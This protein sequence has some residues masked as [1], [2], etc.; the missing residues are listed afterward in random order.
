MKM[1]YAMDEKSF[2]KIVEFVHLKTG[3]R[4][5]E[6][7]KTM[8]I[9]RLRKHLHS[10]KLESFD[11]Y[12]DTIQ[13]S[14][15]ET[16]IFI[17]LVTTNE[18][19][20]FR[21]ERVWKYFREDFLPDWFNRNPSTRLKIWSAASSTGEE[22]YSLGILCEEFKKKNPTFNYEIIGTD[23]STKVLQLAEK[24]EYSGRSIEKFKTN[25]PVM[26]DKFMVRINEDTFQ[27][28]SVVRGHV[29]FGPHNLFL[30]YKKQAYFDI[31]F[32]RNVLIYFQTKDQE[33]V[34]EKI[35]KSMASDSI[36]VVG[37]SE[38]LTTIKSPFISKVPLIYKLGN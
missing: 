14:S 26:F 36:L 34:L 7:K 17:N 20:F 13:S 37:E 31:V 15:E 21:T 38:T 27:V 18:T 11:R 22:A 12:V 24:G 4:M 8:L 28:N 2:T 6:S 9:G 5:D 25:E 35:S 19:H 29:F 33:I 23:V 32:L 30:T 1:G 16:Q 10:L 3:I